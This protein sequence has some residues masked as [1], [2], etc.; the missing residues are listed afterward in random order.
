MLNG[1][2]KIGIC[3]LSLTLIA[4]SVIPFL[5]NAQ[6]PSVA[7][8][9]SLNQATGQP[10]TKQVGSWGI[11]ADIIGFIFNLQGTGA[12]IIL[13]FV[14]Q[15]VAGL[16]GLAGMILDGVLKLTVV[17][18]AS[19]IQSMTAINDVWKVIRDLVNMS[20]IFIL[21]YHGIRMVLGLGS[22]DVKKVIGGIVIAAILVNFSLFF[23]KALIDASNIVTLGFYNSIS[24]SSG[25]LAAPT[26]SQS[27]SSSAFDFTFSGAFMKPLGVSGLFSTEGFATLSQGIGTFQG[28]KL[29]V[30]YICAIIF[31]LLC[32]FVFLAVSV[33]FVARFIGIVILLM[34]SPVAFLSL[35]I[36][37]LESA[38][39]KYWGT[40]SSQLLFGPL[41]MLYS[42]VILSL[43][44]PGGLI[45]GSEKSLGE[46]ILKPEVG[47]ITVIINFSILIGLLITS[48]V[49]AKKQAT[50]GGIITNKWLDKGQEYM[51]GAI[52]GSAGALGRNTFGRAGQYIAESETLKDRAAAGSKLARFGLLAGNKLGASSY[53]ARNTKTME[54]A[55]GDI[56]GIGKVGSFGKGG[57]VKGYKGAVDAAL[58]AQ[59][60]KDKARAEQFKLSDRTKAKNKALLDG[61][62]KEGEA[63]IE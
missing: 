39:Q 17:E 6:G 27:A 29:A 63:F 2:R 30:F 53:D 10:Q 11:G 16:L 48:L 62:G 56:M 60:E 5:V 43:M 49:E 52:F 51:G 15:I 37:G 31:M 38:K 33:L 61:E 23:T 14:M 26:G 55:T 20:F 21:L 41:Y 3:I 47:T 13:H 8:M 58:K 18:M 32:T 59:A 45:S 42:W 24:N 22:A 57:G 7:T 9:D 34:M 46:A 44:G 28:G 19:R 35:G 50:S 54:K 12:S 25:Q 40:L 36:P 1:L 4:V